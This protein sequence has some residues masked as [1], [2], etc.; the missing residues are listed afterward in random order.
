MMPD[1]ALPSTN[2]LRNVDEGDGRL[3]AETS[4][5]PLNSTYTAQKPDDQ[6]LTEATSEFL[7]D[8]DTYEDLLARLKPILPEGV[9]ITDPLQADAVALAVVNYKHWSEGHKRKA[10][11]DPL[12]PY[13]EGSRKMEEAFR[14]MN[15]LKLLIEGGE[16][17]RESRSSRNGDG[18]ELHTERKVLHVERCS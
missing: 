2:M 17:K 14:I 9:C 11:A 12:C 13:Q 1:T 7:V 10:T 6:N 18:L 3:T 16:S 8:G 15:T 4:R 5:C